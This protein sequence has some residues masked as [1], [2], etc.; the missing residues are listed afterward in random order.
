MTEHGRVIVITDNQ[1]NTEV[2]GSIKELSKEHGL[3]YNYLM[4]LSYPY[5]YRG[6]RFQRLNFRHSPASGKVVFGKQRKSTPNNGF[7]SVK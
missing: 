5:E 7:K 6:V 4:R 1:G 2:W 3:A